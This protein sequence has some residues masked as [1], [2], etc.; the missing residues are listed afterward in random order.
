MEAI[1]RGVLDPPHARRMT[2][3]FGAKP[4]HDTICLLSQRGSAE[5][6]DQKAD[7][8]RSQALPDLAESCAFGRTKPSMT[9]ESAGILFVPVLFVVLL[10]AADGLQL[11]EYRVDVEII[12]LLLGRLEFRLLAG[13]LGSRQQ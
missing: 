10:L 6:R 12:A 8:G 2:A 11:G 7:S 9:K 13:G 4:V 1:F 5:Q 3:C